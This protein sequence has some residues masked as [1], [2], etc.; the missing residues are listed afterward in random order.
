MQLSQVKVRSSQKQWMTLES[1]IL[2]KWSLSHKERTRS[3]LDLRALKISWADQMQVDCN[4]PPLILK[5]LQMHSGNNTMETPPTTLTSRK[6]PLLVTWRFLRCLIERSN[7]RL[8]MM[9]NLLLQ[10][11]PEALTGRTSFLRLKESEFSTLST[12]LEILNKLCSC[13]EQR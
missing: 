8:L 10:H 2:E 9:T 5:K 6:W 3:R 7:G 13:S 4:T 12:L 11:S 1:I